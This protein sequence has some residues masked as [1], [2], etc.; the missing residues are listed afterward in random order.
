MTDSTWS[1]E[2]QRTW[3]LV[4]R[5]RRLY[6]PPKH[7]LW[8]QIPLWQWLRT[9]MYLGFVSI[10]F[11]LLQFLPPQSPA[12]L[13]KKIHAGDEVIQVNHQTV[14]SRKSLQTQR[15]GRG[16]SRG[17]SLP[18]VNT[19]S[20]LSFALHSVLCWG[21]VKVHD[22]CYHHH[23]HHHHHCHHGASCPV[24]VSLC[25]LIRLALGADYRAIVTRPLFSPAWLSARS[26]QNLFPLSRETPEGGVWFR[27]CELVF[28][29]SNSNKL[30]FCL[31]LVTSEGSAKNGQPF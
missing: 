8:S 30:Y 9:L 23:H 7:N 18:C 31:Q 29:F 27:K 22:V 24:P 14:V 13:C 26:F 20:W 19:Y 25:R 21:D 3:V 2:P 4:S 11:F 15:C 6:A 16:E 12:D 28:H 17:M 10:S 1:P 5:G